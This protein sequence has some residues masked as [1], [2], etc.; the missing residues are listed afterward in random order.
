MVNIGETF[1][2]RLQS[3]W[4]YYTVHVFYVLGFISPRGVSAF[5]F[6]IIIHYHTVIYESKRIKAY[7]SYTFASMQLKKQNKL[8]LKIQMIY[9]EIEMRNL[10]QSTRWDIN[11][12]ICHWIH[13]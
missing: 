5:F 1:M 6:F 8:I 13:I 2:D 9:K 4:E 10:G 7:M 12:A 11:I 3:I